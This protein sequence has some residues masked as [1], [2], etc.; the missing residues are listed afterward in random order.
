M[1]L[2]APLTVLTHAKGLAQKQA[3]LASG[4]FLA[5][6]K[7]HAAIRAHAQP[8]GFASKT[9]AG[10]ALSTVVRTV[11]MATPTMVTRAQTNAN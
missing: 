6:H 3:L 11:T 5:T 1:Y 4:N 9:C 7:I 8:L 10:M 2:A